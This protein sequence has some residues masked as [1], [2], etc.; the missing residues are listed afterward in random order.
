MPDV[1]AKVLIG[2]VVGTL[3]GITGL[4]GGVL[5]LPSLIFGLGVPPIVAVGSD[6]LCNFITKG[7]S[8]LRRRQGSVSW[9]LALC[10]QHTRRFRRSGSSGAPAPCLQQWR[11]RHTENNGR[12]RPP[13]RP[14]PSVVAG[15]TSV[16]CRVRR[17]AAKRN[18]HGDSRDRGTD[19]AA[20]WHDVGRIRQHLMMLLLLFYRSAP[21][22]IVGSD[23]AHAVVLTGTGSLLHFRLGT[24]DMKL[25]FELVTGAVP[26]G[27]IRARLSQYVPAHWL[28]RVL[29]GMLLATGA[30]TSWA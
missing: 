28:R 13:N 30:R 19:G 7:A 15:T 3:I 21:R 16:R 11:E 24:I 27:L 5:L 12:Y 22:T 4:G 23:I 6:M 18:S 20:G 10:R 29:C 2:F 26:G 1:G 17:T 9:P 14:G 8:F 25:V